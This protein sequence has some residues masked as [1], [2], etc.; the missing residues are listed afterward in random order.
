MAKAKLSPVFD[1]VRGA[2]GDLVFKEVKGKTIWAHKPNQKD[3]PNTAQVAFTKRALRAR[4]Y[5]KLVEKDPA[6]LVLYQEAAEKT[7]ITVNRLATFDF[8]HKPVVVEINPIDYNGKIGDPIRFVATDD[9]GV[10]RA[11]VT[12]SDAD[13][14]T[15]IE[16]GEAVLPFEGTA[17]WK[18]TATKA[19]P[20]GTT[21][22]IRVEAFDRPY[23]MGMQDGT[24]RIEQLD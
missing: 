19:V 2:Y 13:E 14:G 5:A 15:L 23:G 17:Y 12:L 1:E 6:L 20:A 22:S 24:K 18:Y 16:K 3:G 4:E 9:F 10:V 7:G 21:V 8:Q 11:I